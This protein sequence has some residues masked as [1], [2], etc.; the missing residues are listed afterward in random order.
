MIVTAITGTWPRSL[1]PSGGQVDVVAEHQ[2]P[3]GISAGVV[4]SGEPQLDSGR[5]RPQ[6]ALNVCRDDGG[7]IF[8]SGLPGA[9]Q[10]LCHLPHR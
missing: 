2:L 9:D 8:G 3:P 5:V 6:H 4:L 10:E 7:Q 1:T